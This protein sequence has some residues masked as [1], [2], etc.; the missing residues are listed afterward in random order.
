MSTDKRTIVIDAFP[1][2]T[3]RAPEHVPSVSKLSR[4][5]IPQSQYRRH[6]QSKLD[7]PIEPQKPREW[8]DP[9]KD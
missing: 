8:W 1:S 5:E 3:V 6:D 4:G 2:L 9:R 7:R